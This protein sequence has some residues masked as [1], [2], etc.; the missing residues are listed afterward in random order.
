M[1]IAEATGG[2]YHPAASAQELN[3]VFQDLPT[4]LITKHEVTEVSVIFA[5]LG[6]VLVALAILLGQAWRPLP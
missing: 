4:S 1:A 3:A 6:L 5:A 2:T